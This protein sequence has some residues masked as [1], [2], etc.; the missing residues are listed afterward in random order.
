MGK[1]KKGSRKKDFGFMTGGEVRST[2]EDRPVPF[3]KFTP[4]PGQRSGEAREGRKVA[5]EGCEVT[6]LRNSRARL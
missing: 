2:L 5:K 6:R 3:E 4:V 1:K